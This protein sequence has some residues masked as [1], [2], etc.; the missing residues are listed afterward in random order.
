M[1][2]SKFSFGG[3]QSLRRATEYLMVFFEKC[4]FGLPNESELTC[5][6][7]FNGFVRNF[8]AFACQFGA[9]IGNHGHLPEEC[10]ALIEDETPIPATSSFLLSRE[11]DF[12]V[13]HDHENTSLRVC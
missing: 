10:E 11:N 12:F 7:A 1:E 3:Q 4:L 13:S 6:E 5:L 8:G 2:V 9:F